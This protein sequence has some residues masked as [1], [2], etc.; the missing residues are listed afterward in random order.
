MNE[1]SKEFSSEW[2]KQNVR[3]II[4][5][6]CEDGLKAILIKRTKPDRIY[7]VTIWWGV[8]AYDKNEEA[9]LLREVSEETNI[10]IKIIKKLDNRIETEW[11]Q[12]TN[13]HLYHAEYISWE[14]LFLWWPE[15]NKISQE[16]QYELVELNINAID[17]LNIVPD[18]V[19]E[20]LIKMLL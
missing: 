20:Q 11:N 15:L 12:I 8:E 4:T 19:K 3:A 14:L 5:K 18:Q 7:Y 2:A 9:T 1:V 16:N 10:K 17:D 6:K 13:T